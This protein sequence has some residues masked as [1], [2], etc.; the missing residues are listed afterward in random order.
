MKQTENSCILMW[1]AWVLGLIWPLSLWQW[2]KA[3]CEL[4]Y[5]WKILS[6]IHKNAEGPPALQFFALD[7]PEPVRESKSKLELHQKSR[8]LKLM[9]CFFSISRITQWP[10]NSRTGKTNHKYPIWSVYVCLFL[11]R[12]RLISN[13]SVAAQCSHTNY[14]LMFHSCVGWINKSSRLTLVSLVG[15]L[16]NIPNFTWPP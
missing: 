10:V 13:W 1:T 6:A 16:Y 2:A 12:R 5:E 7:L 14:P 15:H 4:N 11:K 9:S 3:C 8:L